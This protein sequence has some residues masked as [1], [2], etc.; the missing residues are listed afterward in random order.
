VAGT[1]QAGP[2]GPW[3]IGEVDF[4][5][6]PLA[7][8]RPPAGG[9]FATA[10]YTLRARLAAPAPA[11]R[12]LARFEDG[13]PWLIEQPVGRGRV[14]FAS[15]TA[16]LEGNDLPTRPVFVPL[17]QRLVLWLAGGLEAAEEPEL[18]AGEQLVLT[19]GAELAGTRVGVVSPGGGRIEAE[20]LPD[21]AVSRAVV[22][23]LEEVGFYRWSRPGR[24]GVAA[25]NA[26][27][28]ESDLTPLAVEE[29]EERL[30]P[31]RAELVE[32]T[33]S[34]ASGDPSRLGVRSLTR[35][36]LVALLALLLVEMIVAGPR[37]SLPA[38]LRRR[39]PAG[40]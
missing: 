21:G 2:D 37:A 20:F 33:P 8:F 27:A 24:E 19:G 9:T 15:S 5:A 26:P 23:A 25:V 29:L 39:R 10:S 6:P 32:V 28:A 14:V 36:L 16:D 3:H 34:G 35:P 31:V 22:P 30:R 17:V 1:E 12:V 11:A 4:A 40:P 38:L 18:G 13:E 7:L